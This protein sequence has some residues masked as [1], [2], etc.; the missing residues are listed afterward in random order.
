[1]ETREF[2]GFVGQ[3]DANQLAPFREKQ[4]RNIGELLERDMSRC[5]RSA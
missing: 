2:D 4:R 3:L 1:M 5:I